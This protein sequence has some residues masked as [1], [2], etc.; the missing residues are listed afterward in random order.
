MKRS[1]S[2]LQSLKLKILNHIAA[3]YVVKGCLGSFFGLKD[4]N[5]LVLTTWCSVKLIIVD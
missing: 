2:M 3:C 1:Q 5:I 4:I